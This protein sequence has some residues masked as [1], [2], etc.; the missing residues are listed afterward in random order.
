[1]MLTRTVDCGACRACCHQR[2]W[3]DPERDDFGAYECERM[4]NGA[5]QLK[6]RDDGACVYLSDRLGCTIHDRRPAMCRA[7]DCGDWY[8][9]TSRQTR[10]RM[11]RSPDEN[12]RK[13][14]ASGRRNAQ[15]N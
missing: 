14:V 9:T 8:A 15:A 3:L 11:E 10:R 1:M 2:V 4:P 7:F 13:M 5:V 12:V 6:K